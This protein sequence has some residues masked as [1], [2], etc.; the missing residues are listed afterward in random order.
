MS[1]SGT[2]TAGEPPSPL[3]V[4]L[5]PGKVPVLNFFEIKFTLVYITLLKAEVSSET[6][7]EIR[8]PVYFSAK[9]EI[10][11]SNLLD[12]RISSCRAVE[13]TEEEG[14]EGR[15]F[16]LIKVSK[17]KLVRGFYY[18]GLTLNDARNALTAPCII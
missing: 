1:L 2:C 16:D 7:I 8:Q 13:E 4:S 14:T 5:I 15:T 11:L 9:P 10:T 17:L 3:N 12:W 6:Q 18:L